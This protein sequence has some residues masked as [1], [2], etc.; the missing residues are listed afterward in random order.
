MEPILY[1]HSPA[2]ERSSLQKNSDVLLA[3]SY[4]FSSTTSGTAR[5]GHLYQPDHLFELLLDLMQPPPV[6]FSFYFLLCIW[7]SVEVHLACSPPH[8]GMF[9]CS[10][11][12][13]CWIL[14]ALPVCSGNG[15]DW[16]IFHQHNFCKENALWIFGSST[17]SN[18]DKAADAIRNTHPPTK[19]N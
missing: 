4:R 5:R 1:G 11:T 3:E 13:P 16:K 2:E 6:K 12:R 9:P 10:T 7:A 8:C 14:R 19:D 18:C 17:L 15:Q